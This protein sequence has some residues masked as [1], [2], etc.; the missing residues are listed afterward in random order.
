[1]FINATAGYKVGAWPILYREPHTD[2]PA[3]ELD[4]T[5]DMYDSYQGLVM[6]GY[7]GWHGTPGDGC[8]HNPAEGWPH[9]ASVAMNPFIFEPGVLRNNIDFWPDVTEYPCTYKA[10][11]GFKLPNGNTA[12]LYSSYDESTVDLHFRWM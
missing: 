1:M 4:T 6:A 12:R 8:P 9:Y 3:K 11:D 2:E 5:S 7:Q 10:P